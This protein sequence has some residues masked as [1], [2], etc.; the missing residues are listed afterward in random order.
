[1]QS[2]LLTI[3]LSILSCFM[4]SAQVYD[5]YIGAGHSQGVTVTSSSNFLGTDPNNTIDGSGMDAPLMEAG[6]FVNQATMGA[7]QAYIEQVRDYSGGYEAWIDDQFTVAPSTMLTT[8]NT[9]WTQVYNARLAGG[10]PADDIF[11]PYSL[12][13]NYAWWQ[14]NMT[15]NDL[16]RQK[17]AYSLSQILVISANSNL[18]DNGE[19]LS[20]YYDILINNSFGNFKDLLTEVSL[21]PS[22]GIY[23]SHFNNPKSIPAQNIFPDENY[24]REI[25]QLFSIGLYELNNNGTRKLDGNG[26]PIPTYDN[27]DIKELAK[28]FTGL[29]AGAINDNVT[30]TNEPYFGLGIWGTDMTVPMKM[31]DDFHET[32]EKVLLGTQTI[33]A[34]QT[35]EQDIADAIDFLFN[36]NNV[37]PFIATRLIQRLVMSNPAPAYVER[38]ANVFNDNG[39]G[40]RGDMKAVV[41]AILLDSDARNCSTVQSEYAARMREPLMRFLHV[42]RSLNIDTPSGN[43]WNNSYDFWNDSK[44]MALHAA[45]VFNFYNP[46]H[47]PV[48]DIADN[49]WVAPEFKLHNTSSSIAMIN[50]ANRWTIWDVFFYSW[51][52]DYGDSTKRLLTDDLEALSVDP[53]AL[54]NQLD[55]IFTHGQLTDETRTIIRDA[56]T[57][58]NNNNNWE[59]TRLALYLIL[60][61]PDYNIVR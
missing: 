17:I 25:M 32:G 6:R 2:L 41:K 8:M 48:G 18:R 46:D 54:I 31:Y 12:H 5:D 14:L 16:L 21:H 33:P 57:P 15:N 52:N 49:S 20:S 22:M 35:G 59:R 7:K 61:S 10:E 39:S 26:D 37:G 51:E 3:S 24:A 40:V 27:N 38:V 42:A 60:I 36:H 58:L 50:H 53:E 45:S 34:G 43:Y 19:T 11:G 44:Q 9:V 55:I 47:Q 30:W 56:I 1:M 13:F 4:L 23:L 28:V 29:G